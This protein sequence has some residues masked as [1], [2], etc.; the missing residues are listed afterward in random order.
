MKKAVIFDLY[1][2]LITE[3]VSDK[4]YSSKCAAD[5]G[6]D[7]GL[8][9][10]VWEASH[11]DMD[12]GKMPYLEVLKKICEAA[13]KTPDTKLLLECQEK[14][15][16][17]KNQC[18]EKRED[19]VIKMLHDLRVNGAKLALCSNCSEDEVSGFF[20]SD[21]RDCFDAVILSYEAGLRKPDEKIFELCTERLGMDA[22]DC[23]Y[24]GDGGSRE[25][26]GAEKAGMQPLRA[27]WFL[28]KYAHQV[29]PM[30]FQEA[31]KPQ[32]VLE[33]YKWHSK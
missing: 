10:E 5:L 26:Y 4:Y 13:G 12:T 3:W 23:L 9:R 19:E 17:T 28:D 8:F 25:L 1:E 18:F 11:Y 6:V 7:N 33:V 21:F 2:T 20:K 22:E 30:P 27:M 29:E 16:T 31:K 15:I 14:R 32:D 24:V